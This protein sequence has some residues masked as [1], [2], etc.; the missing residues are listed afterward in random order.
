[1]TGMTD[2]ANPTGDTPT[3]GEPPRPVPRW[4]ALLGAALTVAMVAGLARQFLGTGLSGLAR[5]V[6]AAPGFYLLFALLYLTPPFADW[7]IFRRLWAL[8]AAEGFAALVRK[9]I[10]N[11]V[12]FGYSGEAYFYA[13]ARA[14]GRLAEA[15]FAGIKDVAILSAMAGNAVT[16][17]A[18]AVAWPF[19]R[20]AFGAAG[21]TGLLVSGG[22]VVATSLP[23]LLFRARV[24]ALPPATLR[25]VFGIQ[26][27]RIVGSS[28]LLALA[29]GVAL[30]GVALGTW[31][32]LSAARLL[33]TRLPL[34]PNKE[35]VFANLAI[36]LIGRDT[37]LADLLAFT[38]GLTLAVH[39]AL[40]ALFGLAQIRRGR[41]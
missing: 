13:W 30:P 22:I 7:I 5:A 4:P 16:L 31:L 33:V 39:L 38:A 14:R 35:L 24:F 25:W 34:L 15:P 3:D 21:M 29:W 36:L 32:L 18:V 27:A 8:P 10:A 28:L 20:G 26:V 12:L 23:F 19:A 6:P 9:R 2:T 37:A 1:M 40:L 41:R 17:A 11:E